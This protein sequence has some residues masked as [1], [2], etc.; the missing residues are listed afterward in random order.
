M[1][2]FILGEELTQ[3]NLTQRINAVSNV[4]SKL[5]ELE[6]NLNNSQ[7]SRNI[8]GNEEIIDETDCDLHENVQ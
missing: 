2:I 6:N 4:N 1:I 5:A 7:S 3:E 8:S